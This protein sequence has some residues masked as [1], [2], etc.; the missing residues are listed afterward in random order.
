MACP[1]ESLNVL[2]NLKST[3]C[4]NEASEHPIAH[5]LADDEKELRSV[6]EDFRDDE[7]HHREIGLKEGAEQAPGFP[8][9]KGAVKAGSKLAIWLSTRI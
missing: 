7:R 3:A 5:C 8:V 6:I 2:I 9:L 4:L 1:G